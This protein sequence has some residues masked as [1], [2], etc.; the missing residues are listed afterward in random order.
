MNGSAIADV[1]GVPHI[2]IAEIYKIDEC[3]QYENLQAKMFNFLIIDGLS[4]QGLLKENPL[5]K[6]A[7]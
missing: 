6:I 4:K 5:N 3:K 7:L 2:D 1:C